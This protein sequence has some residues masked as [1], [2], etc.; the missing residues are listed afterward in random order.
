MPAPTGEQVSS[1]RAAVIWW[2]RASAS[3]LAHGLSVTV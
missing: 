2:E 3:L 1:I